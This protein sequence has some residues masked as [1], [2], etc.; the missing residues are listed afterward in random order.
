MFTK[1]KDELEHYRSHFS[2][3]LGGVVRNTEI[4]V[5]VFPLEDSFGLPL[6]L[7]SLKYVDIYNFIISVSEI[8]VTV[9]F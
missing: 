5:Y 2:P 8:G 3:N 4:Q 1:K 6:Y 7:L 9:L